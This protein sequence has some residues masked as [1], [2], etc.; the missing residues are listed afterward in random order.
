MMKPYEQRLPF[1]LDWNLLRTFMV[2]AEQRGITRAADFLG[3]RQPTI[4]NALRRLED[5]FGNRLIDRSPGH[6]R[7]TEAGEVLFA[8]CRSMFQTVAQLPGAMSAAD[9]RVT[10]H[11][12]IAVTSHV[13]SPH[14]D[15]VLAEF[16]RKAPD[17]TF[18]IT[19]TESEDVLNR[20]RQNRATFGICLMHRPDP[21]LSAEILFR[22]RFRLYCGPNHRLF[23]QQGLTLDALAGDDSVSFQTDVDGGP[24]SAVTRLRRQARLKPALRG[25]S[26]NLHEVRRMIIAG[27]GIGALPV[28][29]AARDCDAG[30]LWPLPPDNDLPTVDVQIVTN[31][32]RMMSGGERALLSALQDMLADV[33]LEDRSY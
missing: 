28:H 25:L 21:A 4:S 9:S 10:G 13:V 24:L 16:G 19:V 32:A 23:G 17:V 31:K 6:F 29:V 26:A 27:I 12:A 1:N 7:L 5:A 33:K 20:L 2:V 30:L 22:E 11:V 18:A 15:A 8:E 3:L 14:L